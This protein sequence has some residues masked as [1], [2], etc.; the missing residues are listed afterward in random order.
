MAKPAAKPAIV[1]AVVKA[2][3]APKPTA[4]SP[5]KLVAPVAAL[6]KPVMA[7][8]V[9]AKATGVKVTL[10]PSAAWPFPSGSRP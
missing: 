4:A 7:K 2:V 6:A 10:N 1:K 8:P 9:L 5:A 3:V